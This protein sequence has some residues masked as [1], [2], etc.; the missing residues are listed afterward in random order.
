MSERAGLMA[1][2]VVGAGPGRCELG[3]LR[4]GGSTSMSVAVVVDMCGG[5]AMGGVMLVGVAVAAAGMTACIRRDNKHE[6]R[7]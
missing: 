1:R 4:D 2:G 6:K 5:V 3:G 7:V